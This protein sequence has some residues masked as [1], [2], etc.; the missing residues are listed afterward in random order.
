VFVR[1]F[2]AFCAQLHMLGERQM[3]RV[4]QESGPGTSGKMVPEGRNG[5]IWYLAALPKEPRQD[6]DSNFHFKYPYLG[7]IHLF[8]H[9]GQ[10]L[11]GR[12]CP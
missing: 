5:L 1:G 2:A 11:V 3:C 6:L 9:S 12:T 4:A 10:K 8:L 7:V